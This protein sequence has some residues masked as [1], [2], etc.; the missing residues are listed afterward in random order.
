MST[1][2]SVRL[3]EELAQWVEENA[4]V[5]GRSQG[6]LVKEA[7]ERVRQADA[8]KPFLALAGSVEGPRNL[9][10]RKGFLRS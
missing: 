7:L 9:S 1:T 4:R 2:L 8:S 6:S 3:P 5:T 10:Q